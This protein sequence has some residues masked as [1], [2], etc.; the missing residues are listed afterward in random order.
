VVV[1][2]DRPVS[3]IDNGI[4]L[5]SFSLWRPVY[6]FTPEPVNLEKYL[7]KGIL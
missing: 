4:E 6:Q 2:S 3:I 1:S 5:N 7:N